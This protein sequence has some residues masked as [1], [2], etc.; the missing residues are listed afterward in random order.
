MALKTAGLGYVGAGGQRFQSS[1]LAQA[2]MP[3]GYSITRQNT[4]E[5]TAAFLKARGMSAPTSAA[6]AST[7]SNVSDEARA[8]IQRAIS[9]YKPGGGFGAGVEAGLER[10]RVKAT[11]SGMQN[12]VSAGLANTTMAAGLGKKYEEEVAAPTRANVEDIRSREIASLET[13]LAQME[14]GGFQ[15]GLDRQFS[16]DQSM[17]NRPASSVMPYIP[18]PYS[19]TS[20][21][22]PTQTPAPSGAQMPDTPNWIG[23]SSNAGDAAIQASGIRRQSSGP[24]WAT[25]NGVRWE[26]D[27]QGQWKQVS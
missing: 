24:N 25:I 27:N 14:Q 6:P 2:S 10:G 1:V 23:G 18:A 5:E 4:P 15:A 17:S 11:T 21:P 22:I 16:V 8:A 7:G 12:L 3:G 26:Q 13:M 20:A 19:P 9:R